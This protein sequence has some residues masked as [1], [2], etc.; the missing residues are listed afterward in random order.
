[1]GNE[2]DWEKINEI[3]ENPVIAAAKRY[4]YSE[5]PVADGRH[6]HYVDGVPT[7]W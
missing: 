7:V 4:Y 3:E 1:M 6:W 2:E 5:T